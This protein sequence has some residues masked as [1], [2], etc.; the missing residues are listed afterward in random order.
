MFILSLTIATTTF[1]YAV[2]SEP[3]QTTSQ[4]TQETQERLMHDTLITSLSPYIDKA[5][6]QYYGYPKQSALFW[7]K[8]LN[9]K[10]EQQGGYSFTVK[11][12]VR[13]FEHAHSSPFG[14]E[15]MT[16][17]VSP[18]GVKVI[19]YEHQGD[20]W[21]MKIDKFKQELLEDIFRTFNLD[22]SSYK[23][24]EYRQLQ[25]LTEQRDDLKSLYSVNEEIN[26][27][28]NKDIKPPYKNFVAPFTFVKDEKAYILFK[29][30]DGTNFVYS[31]LKKNDNK[32]IVIKK[33]SLQGKEMPKELL[34]Y[35]FKRKIDE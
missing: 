28:L 10:R 19:S 6:T 25:Y 29:K 30:T 8:I 11:L 16:M 4:E 20:E 35:M 2:H 12:Q 18:F 14:N 21:E 23:K 34:W 9:I 1:N 13:T 33:E 15:T 26:N 5:I 24:Y 31:L 32:W 3:P 22:L 27:E 7:T 17:S